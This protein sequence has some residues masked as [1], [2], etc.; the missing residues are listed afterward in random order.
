MNRKIT[1]SLIFILA[2]LNSATAGSLSK[3]PF[4]IHVE[5]TP[6]GVAIICKEGCAWKTLSF[7]CGK[8]EKCGSDI[9][10]MGM[11]AQ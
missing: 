1:L 11:V 10:F 6:N 5:H 8:A 7:E 4:L 3:S 9:D 2:L